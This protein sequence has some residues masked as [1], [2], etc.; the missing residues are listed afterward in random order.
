MWQRA[1]KVNEMFQWIKSLQRMGAM[2]WEFGSGIDGFGHKYTL[3]KKI[4]SWRKR[5]LTETYTDFQIS[6]SFPYIIL[7][8]SLLI[9]KSLLK[10]IYQIGAYN[11][12]Y[13]AMC[14]C[15][16]VP[17]IYVSLLVSI[18]V[19]IFIYLSIYTC[20][21]L[22]VFV[23]ILVSI[24]HLSIHISVYLPIYH[25]SISIQGFSREAHIHHPIS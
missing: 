10:L 2:L 13:S 15:V 20:I 21:Y 6:H 16:F 18:Y 4:D 11:V 14:I 24:Y 23:S 19:S 5:L 25:L 9:Y 12:Y 7:C 3:S 1:G 22:P 17:I 8:D